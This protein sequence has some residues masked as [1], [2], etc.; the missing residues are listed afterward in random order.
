MLSL[1]RR[2]LTQTRTRRMATTSRRINPSRSDTGAAVDNPCWGSPTQCSLSDLLKKYPRETSI[3]LE[4]PDYLVLNKPPDLRMDGDYP[5]TVQKLLMYWY[6]PPSLSSETD[7]LQILSELKNPPKDLELRHCHQ[8]DYATSG[9][10]L[11][12]RS[13]QA[14]NAAMQAFAARQV[15]KVYLAMVHGDVHIHKE[16]PVLPKER[17]QVLEKQEEQYRQRKAKKRDDTFQGFLPPHSMFQKWKANYL[18][19]SESSGVEKSSKRPKTDE[20]VDI[21]EL[22]KQALGDRD[23]T[24]E[25]STRLANSS[26][27]DVK[28][29]KEWKQL[30]ERL[31]KLYNDVTRQQQE[32]IS[33]NDTDELDLPKL[34][35]VEGE[36]DNAFYVFAPL[37]EA[38]N[39]FAMRV[40]P[41]TLPED[42]MEFIGTSDLDYKPSLTRCVILE[43][44]ASENIPLT[45][46]QLEPKTGRR[47]QLRVHMLIADTIIVGDATYESNDDKGMHPRMCLHAHKLSLPVLN[48]K[49]LTVTAPDPFHLDEIITGNSTTVAH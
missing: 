41:G 3:L 10:L 40:K 43:K 21:A 32:S 14:A 13:K 37:A 35:R 26:W 22:W 7:L 27:K 34:F 17:L 48:G 47:H 30:M 20:R 9:V 23:F 25:E 49:Q 11:F 38:D 4:T 46:V 12:A 8:L 44:G 31:A 33:N 19:Q 1:L 42:R 45:K 29:N 18:K 24:T 28:R 36:P 6:P 15:Q 39:D 5:A 16:W 2:H